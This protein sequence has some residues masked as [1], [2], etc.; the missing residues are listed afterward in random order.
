MK[1]NHQKP[2]VYL[3]CVL[4]HAPKAFLEDYSY[5]R[6]HILPYV[7]VLD[8]LGLKPPIGDCFQY[9]INCV[10]RCDLLI[11][12]VTYPSI[13]VGME[14]GIAY[15]S[16]KPIISLADDRLAPERL[17]AWGYLDPLHFKLRYK[18]REEAASF[19]ISKVLELFPTP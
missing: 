19:V 4:S 14:F 12:N 3:A 1:E 11:A 8:F 13:G 16:R 7:E 9:D 15:E 2:R 17:L 5:I 18:T 6:Q 10:R